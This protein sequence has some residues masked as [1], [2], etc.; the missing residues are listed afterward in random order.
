MPAPWEDAWVFIQVEVLVLLTKYEVNKMVLDVFR[1]A[2]LTETYGWAA[3]ST[4]RR[5][6]MATRKVFFAA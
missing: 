2:S 4:N 5:A 1:T 3:L 6:T